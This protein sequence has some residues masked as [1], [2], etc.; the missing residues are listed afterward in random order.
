MFPISDSTKT[1]KIPFITLAIIL[2]NAYVFYKQLSSPNQEAFIFEYALVPSSVNFL[3]PETLIPFVTSMFLHG[4]FLHIIS[5]MWFLWIFGDNVE[6]KLGAIKFILLYIL[7]GIIGG[8]SQFLINPTS[9]IPMLGASGAVSGILGA[10]F[11]M[12]PAA[13]IRSFIFLFFYATITK[14]P[15]MIY[16]F[17]W[18]VI[19][20]FSGIMALPISYQSGGVAFFAHIGGFAAGLLLAKTFRSRRKQDIIEGE[21]IE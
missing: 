16:I 15:A 17:Y 8:A 18:F 4:G 5:N 19:Q 2:A 21:I 9:D 10:Y 14:I 7:A 1:G 6:A 12:F 13:S 20:L 3:N 11:I